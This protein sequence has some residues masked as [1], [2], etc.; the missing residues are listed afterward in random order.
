M[1]KQIVT[2]AVAMSVLF[3]GTLVSYVPS[4]S[5]APTIAAATGTITGNP[6]FHKTPK[7]GEA[8]MGTVKKG[9]VVKV[10][11]ITNAYW[12]KV[13][14]QGKAG[15]V[16][17][18]YISVAANPSPSPTPTPTPAPTPAPTLK[19]SPAPAQEWEK[20]A[21]KLIDYAKSIMNKVEYQHAK[22]DTSNPNKLIL[23]CS[24]Y[25]QYVYKQALGITMRWG[26][27]VQFNGFPH[28]A[29]SNLRKG[30]L[31]FFSVSTPGKI[32]HVGIYIGDG[33]FIHNVNT[34]SDVVISDINS[35]YY[36]SHYINAARPIQ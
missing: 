20:K 35:S 16:S 28:V 1:K 24:S 32:G 11:E 29:K 34:K 14:Y 25:T 21:D 19:P 7:S 15:W 10:L 3:G 5:A 31:V 6:Y 4:V 9:S 18:R 36:K 8:T 12:V 33:K 27:N 2:A 26:A 22:R 13:E 30:D 17:S 23:D